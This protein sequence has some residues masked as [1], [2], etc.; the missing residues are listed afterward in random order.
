M[1]FT[2]PLFLWALAGLSVPIAIHL[3]SRKEGKVIRLGS[4]RHLQE[5]STQQFKGI[6]LNEILLLASRSLLII[7]FVLLISGIHWPNQNTQRWL[8][9]E[10]DLERNPIAKKLMDSLQN[11]GF[12]QHYLQSGFPKEKSVDSG[13]S[14]YW[15]MISELE[16]LELQQAIVL[17]YSRLEE[18]NGIRKS[19]RSTIQ[20]ITFPAD[21]SNFIAEAI[22]QTPDRTLIR[23]GHSSS[24]HTSFETEFYNNPIID[25]IKI[26]KLPSISISIVSDRRF[27]KD[28]QI[29]RA[30]L[31]AIIKKLPIEIIITEF[32]FEKA[33]NNSSDWLIWLSDSTI[34]NMNSVKIV[35]YSSKPSNQLI[36]QVEHNRWTINK[37]LR[38][39]VAL[40]EN[41]TLQLANL[42]LSEKERWSRIAHHDKRIL[43]DSILFGGIQSNT[44]KASATLNPP[45]NKYIFLLFL[46]V[47]VIE[48]IV[49]YQRNQ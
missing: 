15:E 2:Q 24:E 20:W 46:F 34:P 42:L 41:L 47:L 10:K 1:Q 48:R 36:E 6:K 25:S 40:Q 43:S 18:F 27:D 39:D 19:I 14:N 11:N 21:S 29:V 30:A 5:T 7:L 8:L 32:P 26:K 31:E 38:V 4:L 13:K 28:Q 23:R 3:L 49:A 22:Q 37:R 16:H 45:I 35:N 44:I 9:V 12:E 33:V 17:S